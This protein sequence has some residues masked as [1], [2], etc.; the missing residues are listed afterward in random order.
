MIDKNNSRFLR[1]TLLSVA[2]ASTML[3]GAASSQAQLEEVIVT[4]QQR[5]ESLQDVPISMIAMS[6]ET[7][8]EQAITK[9]EDFTANMPAVTV[10]QNPIGNFVFI[11]GVGT[12]GTNQGIEQSVAI[13]NDG[14][15]MGRH[16]QSRAPFMD[17]ARIEVLR[18]PQSILFGKNTIGG[19]LS[20][21]TAKPTTEFEGS[22]Q[23]LYGTDG[24]QELNGVISGPIT[25]SLR[26]RIA[27]RGYQHDGYLENVVN[28]GDD[29]ERD[30]QTVRLAVEWDASDTILVNAKYERNEFE[31]TGSITQLGKVASV[32]F[33]PTAALVTA[34]NRASVAYATGGDGIEKLDDERAVFNDGG[35]ILGILDPS[36]AG[37]PGFPDKQEGSDNE[38]DTAH[39]N[40]EF[41]LGE[42]TLTFLTGYSH[43]EYRDI[44]DCDF[45]ALPI[46]EVDATEDYDQFSQE[47]RLTSPVGQTFEYIGGLYYHNADLYYNSIEAFGLAIAGAPNVT[48]SYDFDQD[49]ELWAVFGSL[50]WNFSDLSRATFGLRYSDEEKEVDRQL[51]KSFTGG[52][53][54]SDVVGLPAGSL[55]FGNT[56][57]EYDRFEATLP[58]VAAA[59]NAGVWEDSGFLG[60]YEHTFEGRKRSEDFIDW[61]INLEHDLSGD[62][63]I[64]AT[65]ST[66][67]KGGGFD[68]RFLKDAARSDLFEYD[69]E[70]SLAFE[71]GFKTTLLD[72]AM[73][74][75]GAIFRNE[76]SD[77]Q[78]SVFD[79]A[80]GFLVTNAA[81][82]ISQGVEM[83][84][85]WAATDNLIISAAGSY[86]D[87]TY[88][89]WETG[90]CWASQQ[91]D[92]SHPE[93]QPGC[94]DGFR[95]ASGDQTPYAPDFAFNLNFDYVLPL[96]DFLEARAILN[97]NYSDEMFTASDLDPDVALQESFSLVDLRL[98]L[99]QVDGS[100]EVAIIGKNLTDEKYSYNNNDQ[101]LVAGNAY[102]SLHRESSYA[103][104]A[105]YRF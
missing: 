29:P 41:A 23:G 66:G 55:A 61:Y 44:C 2:I 85:Q 89:S 100:W 18:G 45:A 57:E 9:M 75:N 31:Q 6:G 48:R 101:P 54:F 11:R 67:I 49:Q 74:L 24:E 38:M 47:I 84:L 95:D 25:D 83:D 99:G 92:S 43:Y 19:A 93:F 69:E 16:Q 58:P 5:A 50:T 94:V 21:H 91:V 28:G 90:A 68:A 105:T 79:G 14:I 60:T 34:L 33:N 86:L 53:D 76:V 27:V 103:L 35:E 20:V 10:A 32:P 37:V 40:V 1:P 63:L 22:V 78:V 59:L 39:L 13:F 4:A 81:E 3:T 88:D 97:Y 30:D 70:E 104:Q 98:S 96:G 82:A 62:T 73:R 64:Y 65:A 7:I 56:A 17:L 46:I 102:N 36:F 77:Q 80:T 72:G 26:G 51:D 8:N 87:S 15:F 12:A 52:W 42:H 71:L